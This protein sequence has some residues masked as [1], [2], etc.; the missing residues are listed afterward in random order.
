MGDM[1]RQRWFK[2]AMEI[3]M[4]QPQ[5]WELLISAPF[6]KSPQTANTRSSIISRA[7]K[8]IFLRAWCWERTADFTA[9]R[10]AV[11]AHIRVRSSHSVQRESYRTSTV[12][13]AARALTRLALWFWAQTQTSTASRSWVALPTL[14]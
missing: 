6:S 7:V 11:A 14:A 9:R 12:S 3:C 13:R 8:D 4:A 1:G 2:G 10:E 5:F